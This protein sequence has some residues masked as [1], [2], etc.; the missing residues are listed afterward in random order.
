MNDTED[1]KW[2]EQGDEKD[3]IEKRKDRLSSFR[4]TIIAGLFSL[5]VAVVT[6]ALGLTVN[7]GSGANVVQNL[8]TG[9]TVIAHVV[10]PAQPVIK[11]RDEIRE[12]SSD[13]PHTD[14]TSTLPSQ[15]GPNTQLL[16]HLRASLSDTNPDNREAAAQ[17][18][19]TKTRD[20]AGRQLVLR[21]IYRTKDPTLR[22]IAILSELKSLEGKNISLQ[23]SNTV[24]SK[25]LDQTATTPD[26]GLVTALIGSTMLI[27]TVDL[28][29]GSFN[30]SFLSSRG[31]PRDLR[32]TVT[33][34]GVQITSVVD[35]GPNSPLP[36]QVTVTPQDDF[37]LMGQAIGVL[38][39]KQLSTGVE[40]P[41][42]M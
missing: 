41:L 19:I 42:P 27:K 29:S 23:F 11:V 8:V 20:E 30:G 36:L 14:T 21:T 28:T 6:W 40:L 16:D 3:R 2:Q 15:P 5:F 12:S 26:D 4:N 9:V 37:K 7:K 38:A 34:G 18:A 24:G 10:S 1:R 32:G 25:P 35:L 33:A 31:S 39:G 17:D 22:S 13:K